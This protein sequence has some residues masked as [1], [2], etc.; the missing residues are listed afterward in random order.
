ME[1][2]VY[3][4]LRRPMLDEHIF[5]AGLL[6]HLVPRMRAAGAREITVHVADLNHAM[7][8]PKT[9]SPRIFGAWDTVS[10]AVHFWLDS[11]D[12]RH[13]FETLFAEFAE[14]ADGYLV[15]ESVV[16]GYDRTWTDGERRPGVTQFALGE[17]PDGVTDE[18]FYHH[19]QDVHSPFS[20][21]LHPRR[22][23][24]VRNATARSLTPNAPPWRFIVLE[25]FR[26]LEDFTD[27]NLYY[28]SPK[29]VEQCW[30]DVPEFLDLK[31]YTGGPMSEYH[32]E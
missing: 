11:V 28:Q 12:R 19:W 13:E 21:D 18:H 1:K 15:T 30:I 5:S 32:F 2:L 25:H 27:E 3:I 7:D 14:K 16:A 17:K 9:T 20:F 24:Y 22:W 10:A 8:T 29:I 23:S 26:T 4:L 6:E 31:T